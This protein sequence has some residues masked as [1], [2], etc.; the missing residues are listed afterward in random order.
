MS[1]TIRTSQSPIYAGTKTIPDGNFSQSPIYAGTKTIPQA[2]FS[3][4]AIY[5]ATKTYASVPVT[6]YCWARQK[7]DHD[8]FAVT[9]VVILPP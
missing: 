6:L 1:D 9:P 5:T 8:I 7:N 2:R 3:Q 4:V